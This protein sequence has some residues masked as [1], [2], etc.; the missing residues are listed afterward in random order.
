PV[1]TFAGC[2][3]LEAEQEGLP[4]PIFARKFMQTTTS[5]RTVI[6]DH[7]PRHRFI[8]L[9]V[10]IATARAATLTAASFQPRYSSNLPTS[11]QGRREA[12]VPTSGDRSCRA[13][14][15]SAS[16]APFRFSH[17]QRRR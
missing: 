11:C 17:V 7:E 6:L 4:V 3:K 13:R 1:V 14:Q 16:S 10:S 15:G 2:F 9:L 12:S 5:T 8:L